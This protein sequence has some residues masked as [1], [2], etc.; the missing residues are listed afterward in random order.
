M[1]AKDFPYFIVVDNK[2]RPMAWHR[3]SKQL[4]YCNDINYNGYHEDD[5]HPVKPVTKQTAQRWI[6]KTKENRKTWGFEAFDK[7]TDFILMP[8]L[9]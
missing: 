2:G 5:V 9:V 3:R 4:C 1:K 8:V 7:D 6:K